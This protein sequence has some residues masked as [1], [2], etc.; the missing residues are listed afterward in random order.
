M[1]VNYIIYLVMYASY[2]LEMSP[3]GNVKIV[4]ITL[5]KLLVGNLPRF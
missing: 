1:L 2:V 5:V 3:I 4:S